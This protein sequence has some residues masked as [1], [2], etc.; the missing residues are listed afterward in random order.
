[1]G[2]DLEC[3]G[4][5][6]VEYEGEH[7]IGSIYQPRTTVQGSRSNFLARTLNRLLAG[8]FVGWTEKIAYNK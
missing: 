2:V 5:R 8:F 3:V 7:G 1:M 6:E 4:L